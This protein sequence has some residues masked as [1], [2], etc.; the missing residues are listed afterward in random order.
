MF[1]VGIGHLPAVKDQVHHQTRANCSNLTSVLIQ[2]FVQFHRVCAHVKLRRVEGS[3]TMPKNNVRLVLISQGVNPISRYVLRDRRLVGVVESAPRPRPDE[4]ELRLDAGVAS[5]RNRVRNRLLDLESAALRRKVPYKLLINSNSDELLEWMTDRRP[6]IVL[7]YSMSQLLKPEIIECARLGVLNLHPSLLP[8]WRGPNP[9]P[10][11][12]LSN[13]HE[14]GYTLHFIDPGEDTGAIVAQHRFAVH[15]GAPGRELQSQS[16]IHFGLPL[17]EQFLETLPSDKKINGRPQPMESSTPRAGRLTP[18][19]IYQLVDW[20]QWS[21]ERIWHC[22]RGIPDLVNFIVQQASATSGRSWR[23]KDLLE[24]REAVR[25]SE[26]SV[27]W[28]RRYPVIK[29]RGGLVP[30][31]PVSRLSL[32]YAAATRVIGFPMLAR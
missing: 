5:L 16:L 10:W 7:V 29:I 8:A 2:L 20:E 6:D 25:F 26:P 22:L 24:I 31:E 30:L 1:P 9:W 15:R 19:E 32:A 12:F 13:C 14:S 23:A 21:S 17:V 4:Q 3:S 27:E 18:S 28:S 11:V